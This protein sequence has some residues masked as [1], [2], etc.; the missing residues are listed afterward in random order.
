MEPRTKLKAGLGAAGVGLVFLLIGLALDAYLHAR[1]PGLAAREGVFALDNPG[2]ALLG[3]G[4]VLIVLGVGTS[5]LA[6]F[7]PRRR[8]VAIAGIGLAVMTAGTVAVAAPSMS[9]HDH[10]ATEMDHHGS[11][12]DQTLGPEAW[13][14]LEQVRAAISGFEN[15]DAAVEAGYRAPSDPKGRAWHYNNPTYLRDDEILDPERPEGLVYFTEDDGTQTLV[16][17]VFKAPLGED[18]PNPGGVGWHTHAPGCEMHDETCGRHI[19]HVW[20]GEDVVNP[21][22]DNLRQALGRRSF[23]FG[24]LDDAA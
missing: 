21:F 2:H 16:G 14:L 17:A 20:T 8:Y 13:E 18:P 19:L 11:A 1:D 9:G 4:L 12:D 22:A 23:E 10:E 6:V 15:E 7:T 5:V 3:A 24:P